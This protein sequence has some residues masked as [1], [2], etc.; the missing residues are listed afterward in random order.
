MI[1]DCFT[2]FNEFDVLEL[3]LRTLNDA[4]DRFVICEAPFTFRGD[5]KPLY[6]ADQAARFAPWMD[7][8]RVIAYPGPAHENP[9]QNEWGQRDY[10]LAGIGN[11][12]PDDLI[13]IGD[14]DEIPDPRFVAQRP[15]PGGILVH[16]M[17]LMRGY[18][19]R[20]DFGGTF[21]WPG[22]RA[23]TKGSIAAYGSLSAVRQ[24]Q[25]DTTERVNSGWHFSSLG[26]AAAMEQ[27]MR[28]YSHAE[29][30]IPYFNDRRRL[31]T[32]YRSEGGADGA[33][34]LP[35]EQLPAP[36]RDDAR[37]Q[38][39][40]WKRL[41]ALD[42]AH[43]MRLEHAHGLCA[44]IPDDA[45]RVAVITDR[46][47]AFRDA[48]T[49]RYGHAFAGA[50]ATADALEDETPMP[51]WIVVDAL[52]RHSP[53][54]LATLRQ[55]GAYVIV[56]ATNARSQHALATVLG[57]GPFAPGVAQGRAEIERS[58]LA[59]GF[60]ITGADRIANRIVP[61]VRLDPETAMLYNVTIAGFHFVELGAEALH[62]FQSDGF[63]LRLT[64]GT[65]RVKA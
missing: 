61:W 60:R 27:K 41:E 39:F 22:T 47:E 49:T 65:D 17:I 38:N 4:V 8:I 18:A 11:C 33:T 28:A 48:G 26:G 16:M 30:D 35:L 2:F 34:E 54:T 23:L 32:F 37:F 29:Y 9:W 57:G 12:A 45:Q 10:L 44:Y 46:P 14:C 51:D 5:P 6:F 40:L 43:A 31:E 24:E 62:D 15:A 36:L 58:A 59:A 64:P 55:T 3:R 21:S 20:A 1:V 19:N 52:E 25:N 13:L 50:F 42:G 53:G 7:R 63:V 56:H